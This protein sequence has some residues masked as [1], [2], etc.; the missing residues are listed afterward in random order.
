MSPNNKMWL[1]RYLIPIWLVEL[2]VLGIYFIL[3]CVGLSAVED[4]DDYL[5]DYVNDSTIS[6]SQADD[7]V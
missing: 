2:I 3:A 6:T 5:D 4:I 1:K 7:V